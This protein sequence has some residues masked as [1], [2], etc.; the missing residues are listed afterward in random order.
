[1][2]TNKKP[3][4]PGSVLTGSAVVD[5]GAGTALQ[6]LITAPTDGFVVNRIIVTSTDVADKVLELTHNM[7]LAGTGAATDMKLGQVKVPLTAGTD[8][9]G[10]VVGVNLLDTTQIP[11]L[12]EDGSIIM[13]AGD[14][15][16]VNAK[17]AATGVIAVS[18]YGG[19]YAA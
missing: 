2:A 17:V 9:T 14:V 6:T 18:A 5:S 10:D 16:K 15:L 3:I 8:A 13:A 1:M 7:K 19:S 4:Y 12:Q 11:G